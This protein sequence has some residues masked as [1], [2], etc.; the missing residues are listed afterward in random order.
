MNADSFR[1]MAE[2]EQHGAVRKMDYAE[3]FDLVI[4]LDDLTSFERMVIAGRL[5]ELVW[6]IGCLWDRVKGTDSRKGQAR[7]YGGTPNRR[8]MTYKLRK[9]AGFSYP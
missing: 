6:G 8:S 9:A 5:G 3:L 7:P 1:R 2:I 4:V